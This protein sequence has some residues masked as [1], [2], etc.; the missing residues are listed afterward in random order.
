MQMQYLM[1]EDAMFEEKAKRALL[2]CTD[3]TICP[4]DCPLIDVN[5]AGG[6][7]RILKRAML[8][9]YSRQNGVISDLKI[10]IGKLYLEN[11]KLK[12][13]LEDLRKKESK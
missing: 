7:Q 9:I 2:L 1:E 11:A 3:N 10:D 12:E 4:M 6:C 8:S 13:E 5:E